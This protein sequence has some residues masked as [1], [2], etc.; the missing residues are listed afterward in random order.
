M[1]TVQ[2]MSYYDSPLGKLYILAHDNGLTHIIFEREEG[3]QL[4][5]NIGDIEFN[6]DVPVIQDAKLWLSI[7]FNGGNPDFMPPLSM[8]GTDF[9]MEVW[10]VIKQIPYGQTMTYGEIARLVGEKRGRRASAQAVGGAV[11]SNPI[12]VIVPCHRVLGADGAITGY[13]GGVDKKKFLL[14][15][16]KINFIE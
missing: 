2:Y 6:D 11:G 1:A 15:L 10:N 7:Y 3:N 4:P 8:A 9:R 5:V 12:P 16:E 13:S 14:G